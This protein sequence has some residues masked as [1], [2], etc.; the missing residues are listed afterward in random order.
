MRKQFHH[1]DPQFVEPVVVRIQ[2]TAV[3]CDVFETIA[4]DEAES[5]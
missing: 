1:R 4:A 3:F 5:S 2:P